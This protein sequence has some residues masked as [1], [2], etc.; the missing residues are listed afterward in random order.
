MNDQSWP[1]LTS[2]LLA[3]EDLAATDTYWA[4]TQIMSGEAT[5]AQLAGFA[6][7]LRAKGETAA[8]VSGLADAMLAM[9]Q[10]L[11]IA[12][13]ALDIVGTGGDMAATVNISTMSAVVAAAAGARVVKH[14]NRASSSQC[15]SADVLVALGVA[16]DLPADAVRRCVDE[17]GIGFAF[18]PTFHPALRHA[19]P[20]RR[21]LGIPTVFNILGPL[22]NPA[23]PSA[24]MVGCANLALAPV[25]ADVLASR[26]TRA[27]VIR[28]E[29]GLD[30]VTI[31]ADT[32]VWDASRPGGVVE[33]VIELERTGISQGKADELTGGT[34]DLNA[35][36]T[37][38]VF[39]GDTNGPL[40]AVRDAVALNTAAA[41]VT[42]D[43][44]NG[45]D[46]LGDITQRVQDALPRAIDAIESGAAAELLDRWAAFSTEA[47][48]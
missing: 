15:G 14:G 42:W 8:E 5:S 45:I 17:L 23:R 38:S 48:R 20:A 28:G 3:G 24:Q 12:G 13:P 30:E 43:A 29:D 40:E 1:T 10:P 6:V 18:A 22:A 26:G 16:I 21:E 19:G 2:A 46:P 47:A 39:A 9:A 37:R 4:M 35:A 27:L 31:F 41:L 25:M 11:E 7:A 44:A 34:A 32:H 36:I 33:D